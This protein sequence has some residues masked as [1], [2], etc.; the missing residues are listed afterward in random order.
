MTAPQLPFGGEYDRHSLNRIQ[1]GTVRA[2]LATGHSV[3]QPFAGG[4]ELELP[5]PPIRRGQPR[6]SFNAQLDGRNGVSVERGKFWE[7]LDL[8]F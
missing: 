6:G 2:V 1:K 4:V 3:V 5:A 8:V 7:H